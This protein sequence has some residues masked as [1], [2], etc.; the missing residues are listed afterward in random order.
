MCE[1]V[2]QYVV[3]VVPDIFFSP[4]VPP[5]S[6][7]EESLSNTPKSESSWTP[8]SRL[9]KRNERGETPL[10]MACIKGDFKVVT[11]LI[12]QGADINTTDNAG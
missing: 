12:D 4:S 11:T 9:Q 5:V 3:I 1:S 10:H 8:R 7:G 6:G 2:V